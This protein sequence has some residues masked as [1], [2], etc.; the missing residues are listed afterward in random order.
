ML[1]IFIPGAMLVEMNSLNALSNL[2][3]KVKGLQSL[4]LLLLRLGY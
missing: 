2:V 1:A 3:Q 4:G